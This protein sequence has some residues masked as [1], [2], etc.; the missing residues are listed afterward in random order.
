MN[1][2]TAVG[3]GQEPDNNGALDNLN[4]GALDSMNY[5]FQNMGM[6]QGPAAAHPQTLLGNRAPL[7]RTTSLVDA[8]GQQRSSSPFANHTA[9]VPQQDMFASSANTGGGGGNG[10]PQSALFNSWLAARQGTVASSSSTPSLQ[11]MATLNQPQQMYQ[12]HGNG[13]AQH[14]MGMPQGLPQGIPP[15]MQQ[16][17]QP[18]AILISSQWKYKDVNGNIQGPFDTAMMT[19]WNSMSYFQPDLQVCRMPT[20]FEP[21]GI[22]DRFITLAD[23]TR[24]VQGK[25]DPFASFDQMATVLMNPQI[26]APGQAPQMPMQQNMAAPAFARDMSNV[27][28]PAQRVSN[29]F[30]VQQSSEIVARSETA[31]P[32]AQRPAAQRPVVPPPQPVDPSAPKRPLQDVINEQ[33]KDLVP[34]ADIHSGDYT[35][36]EIYRLKFADGSFYHEVSVPVP[37]NR[38]HVRRIDADTVIGEADLGDY[39]AI[40]ETLEYDEKMAQFAIEDE[41]KRKE[42]ERLAEEQRK[43]QALLQEQ[44]SKKEREEAALLKKKEKTEMMA[45]KLLEE[46]ERADREMK[47]REEHKIQKKQKKLREQHEKA[48]LKEKKKEEHQQKKLNQKQKMEARKATEAMLRAE[49]EDAV[50]VQAEAARAPLESATPPETAK[51]SEAPWA[52]SSSNGAGIPTIN[53]KEKVASADKKKEQQRALDMQKARELSNKFLQEDKE[54]ESRKAVLNWASSPSPQTAVPTIDIKSQ[55]QKKSVAKTTVKKETPAAVVDDSFGDANFIE[56]QK[57]LWEQVQRNNKKTSSTPSSASDANSWTTVTK[58]PNSSAAKTA[59]AVKTIPPVRPVNKVI[60]N[61]ALKKPASSGAATAT[62]ASTASKLTNYSGN[63]SISARQ[64]FLKW[65]KSQMKLN[66][67]ISAN[68]VLETILQFPSGASSNALIADIIY[69]SSSIMDGRR[70]ATEFSKRRVECEKQVQDPLSWSEALALP[71]GQDDD[72]EFQVVSKKKGRKH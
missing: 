26:P 67:G 51:S 72:W 1:S 14:Q 65:C 60:L 70:F 3:F 64:S 32:L 8:I 55:L 49:M 63:A 20:S 11:A 40:K 41:I 50:D 22:S 15:F 62:A 54:E 27:S 28:E 71:E 46:Q 19:Q 16:Q 17:Q 48:L 7:S 58:K 12:F 5:Q 44:Q 2:H 56:E 69:S 43:E 21:F 52:K 33:R 68:S 45:K 31:T 18:P 42:D 6:G 38:S 39:W 34:Q 35:T 61:P 4:S 59:S 53:L 24:L 25:G 10:P 23:L 9:N 30:P 29:F 37:V 36:D 13:P 57:K 66:P 47:K